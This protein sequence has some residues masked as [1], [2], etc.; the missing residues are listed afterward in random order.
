MYIPTRDLKSLRESLCRAQA[1]IGN[2]DWDVDAIR[3]DLDR[4]SYVIKEIDHHRPLGGDGKH[5]D[6][7]TPTCGCEDR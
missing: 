6:L 7:H 1:A 2:R 4:I 3:R 5:R